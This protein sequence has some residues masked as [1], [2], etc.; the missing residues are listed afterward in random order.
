MDTQVKHNYSKLKPSLFLLP[1]LLLLAIALFLY[2]Q[3]ALDPTSYVNVQKDLFY[4]LNASLGQFPN[5]EYNLTQF[6]DALIFLS[7][8]SIFI[9]YAPSI[10]E[11]LISVS[12]ISL[13][14]SAVLKDIFSVP[15]PAAILDTHS[16][17]IIGQKLPGHSSLPS[18]HSITI[19]TTLTVLLFAFMPQ[20]PIQRFVWVLFILSAGLVLVST[21][22]GVGAHYP[23]D[24]LVG[25]TVGYMSGLAGIF[26]SRTFKVWAWVGNKRYY[27]VMISLLIACAIAMVV[28][29]ID[30]PLP[31]FYLPLAVLIFSLYK[32]SDVYLK[33]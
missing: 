25:G 14:V 13:I 19:F 21:R 8:L 15:R 6:G 26:F 11:S 4:Y 31:V 9:I 23:L 3:N 22:V 16:F 29:I 20:K 10:W 30:E 12:L 2:S 28:K 27:P 24:V 17:I 5:I 1:V 18:G 32:M 33:K 7:L